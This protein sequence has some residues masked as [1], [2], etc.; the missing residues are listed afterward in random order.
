MR[1]LEL[2]SC[3]INYCCDDHLPCSQACASSTA[4]GRWGVSVRHLTQCTTTRVLQEL[5]SSASSRASVAMRTQGVAASNYIRLVLLAW[6]V[7]AS[8]CKRKSFLLVLLPMIKQPHSC[9]RA[10][11]SIATNNWDRLLLYWPQ[12]SRAFGVQ[13]CLKCAVVNGFIHQVVKSNLYMQLSCFCLNCR[14][15]IQQCS[16]G[17]KGNRMQIVQF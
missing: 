15:Q 11:C 13:F 4:W 1:L 3:T 2:G 10:A 5:T 12:Y 16:D 9:R 17:R 6:H 8:A 7:R 14:L